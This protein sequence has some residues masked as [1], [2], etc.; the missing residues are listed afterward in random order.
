MFQNNYNGF[1]RTYSSAW[2]Q[3]VGNQRST[4][5]PVPAAVGRPPASVTQSLPVPDQV[6]HVQLPP[7]TSTPRPELPKFSPI[8][9]VESGAVKNIVMPESTISASAILPSTLGLS[10]SPVPVEIAKPVSQKVHLAPSVAG[11][12]SET[13]P[14][15]LDNNNNSAKVDEQLAS[16]QD[17][18]DGPS[19]PQIFPE[20]FAELPYLSIPRR[21]SLAY[22]YHPFTPAV[23][24]ASAKIQ[25]EARGSPEK[26]EDKPDEV[27]HNSFPISS[28][29]VKAWQA[30]GKSFKN[31]LKKAIIMPR[32]DA[33]GSAS[34]DAQ[35]PESADKDKEAFL[36]HANQTGSLLNKKPV[37]QQGNFFYN[38]EK[39]AEFTQLDDDIHCLMPVPD[40][41][42][43]IK[44]LKVLLNSEEIQNIQQS[45]SYG[46][47][48]E[49]H[50][51]AYTRAA[52]S[53]INAVLGT[54]DPKTQEKNIATLRDAKSLLTGV[55]QA[56]EQSVES[57]IYVHAG[58]TARLRSDFLV[59]Q[60]NYIPLHV[61]QLLLHE[62]FGGSGLFN[63]HI[64][65]YVPDIEKHNAKLQQQARPPPPDS[66]S[67][68][69]S[70]YHIPRKTQNQNQNTHQ[71]PSAPK[72]KKQP[73]NHNKQD[74]TNVNSGATFHS[75][76][77]GSGKKAGGNKHGNKGAGRGKGKN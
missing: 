19:E 72:S 66:S 4:P 39:F 1:N 73:N 63:S 53:S 60:G 56:L 77:K 57:M 61:K 15:V 10:S 50:I 11:S 24:A 70:G 44:D 42:F 13:P 69:W 31:S 48:A 9:D 27:A 43:T 71:A 62:M 6:S 75:K 17:I 47:Y 54:L 36:L 32:P 21:V 33:E 29:I 12:V 51:T 52:R 28:F 38:E 55:A 22:K 30:Q 26:R 37:K 45:L 68:N 8:S 3:P 65:Q 7:S 34:A 35:K 20:N 64:A 58:I 23:S 49:S 5:T 74:N 40:P 18:P 2:Q 14:P 46:L 67:R 41:Q 16:S 59:M 25:S 76:N